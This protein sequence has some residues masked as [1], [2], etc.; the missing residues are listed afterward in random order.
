MNIKWL[1]GKRHLKRITFYS[2]SEKSL[3]QRRE[4]NIDI[5]F[6]SRKKNHDRAEKVFQGKFSLSVVIYKKKFLPSFH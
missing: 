1:E 5:L 4:Y 2:Q 3:R 6:P